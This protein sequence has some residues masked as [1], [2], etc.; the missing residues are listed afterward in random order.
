[1][2]YLEQPVGVGFSTGG[3]PPENEDDIARDVYSFLVNFYKVFPEYLPYNFFVFGESYAGMYAPSVARRVY[4]ET[5][6]YRNGK[7]S[8]RV[9]VTVG[10]LA[11]GNGWVDARVQ[12]CERESGAFFVKHSLV[13][14]LLLLTALTFIRDRQRSIMRTGTA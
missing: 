6:E 8:N 2:L 11:L 13:F 5:L 9:N 10:G 12:V 1:M 4:L 14:A 7:T 3:P